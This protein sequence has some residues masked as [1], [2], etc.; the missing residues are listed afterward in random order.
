MPERAFFLKIEKKEFTEYI[1]EAFLGPFLAFCCLSGHK[2]PG[3]ATKAKK[4]YFPCFA[5]ISSKDTV[6]SV[7]YSA[8]VP[9]FEQIATAT[10]PSPS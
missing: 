5:L 2:G 10:N 7:L 1:S 4:D 8:Y 9:H 3:K 6:V